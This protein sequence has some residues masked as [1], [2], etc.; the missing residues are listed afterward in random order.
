MSNVLI[1]GGGPISQSQLRAEL[2]E[3]PDLIIAADRGGSYLVELGTFPQVLL[4]DFDSLPE[5]VLQQMRAAK[6]EIKS[7]S[8]NKDYT[9]LELALDFAIK[10]GASRIHILGGLGERIDHT[11]GNIGLLLKPLALGI[12]TH[13]MDESHDIVVTKDYLRLKRKPG[14]AVSLIPLSLK[15][16]GITTTGLV[17]QLTKADLFFQSTRGIH[18]EFN[19]ET[20]S[21]EVGEGILIVICF[22]EIKQFS[23]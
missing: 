13:L 10:R 18:N 11:L 4:G 16:T 22:Q 8:V 17:Y 5:P 2:V 15:V 7:F 23:H 14:W 12:E 19:K 9:D 21:I 3:E 6:V 20:A 1:V